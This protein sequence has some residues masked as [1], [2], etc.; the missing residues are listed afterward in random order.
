M[1]RFPRRIFRRVVLPAVVLPLIIAAPPK[2]TAAPAASSETRARAWDALRSKVQESKYLDH[3]L[4][5]EAIMRELAVAEGDDRDE[6]DVAGLLHD[7]DIGTTAVDLS[8]HGLVGAQILRDLGF[9]SAIVH[10]VS[11]HDDRAGVARTSRLD[12]AVYCADQLYWLVAAAGSRFQSEKLNTADPEALW[13]QV[14]ATPSKRAILGQVSNECA[15]I[16]FTMPRALAAVK[17]ASRRLSVGPAV[18]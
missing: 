11:A 18:P 13:E 4:A 6:W 7:I 16:G 10:A 2:D 3:T 8:R 12:H 15:G 17:A 14:Q 9:S 1:M 5:V